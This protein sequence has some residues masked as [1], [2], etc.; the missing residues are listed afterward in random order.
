MESTTI[1]LGQGYYWQDLEVG[2]RFTTFSR[3]IT[4]SDLV[5]FINV[6][7][8]LEAIFIDA[9]FESGVITGRPVPAALTY[10]IIEGLILQSMIQGTGL[11]SL[12][13]HQV[14]KKP[15]RVNDSISATIS[16]KSLRE[17]SSGGKAV[18]VSEVDVMN[19]H[20]ECV[21]TYT[22]TRLLAGRTEVV[23][24]GAV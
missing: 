9:D 22:V 23:Q 15:V 24:V 19:Q 13:V 7:G 12:E 8:M 14:V 17:T 3:T 21:M 18:V 4:E 1:R 11:A 10:T 6:T 2:Q 5:Q 16:I 20:G